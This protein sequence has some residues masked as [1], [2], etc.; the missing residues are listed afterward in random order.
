MVGPFVGKNREFQTKSDRDIYDNRANIYTGKRQY[1][2][3]LTTCQ[4]PLRTLSFFQRIKFSIEIIMCMYV[5]AYCVYV[6]MHVWR[7]IYRW[8]RF[9]NVLMSASLAACWPTIFVS[10]LERQLLHTLGS[11]KS[12]RCIQYK[13]VCV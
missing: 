11:R 1:W 2:A 10:C 13:R 6:C 7:H 8:Q 12:F 5:S 9:M 4:N 3:P